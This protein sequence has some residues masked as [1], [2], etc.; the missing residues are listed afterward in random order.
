MVALV[1]HGSGERALADATRFLS[2]PRLRAFKRWR[3]ERMAETVRWT[4]GHGADVTYKVVILSGD[5]G[6]E[7]RRAPSVGPP[8]HDKKLIGQLQRQRD[9]GRPSVA[10]VCLSSGR[11]HDRSPDSHFIPKASNLDIIIPV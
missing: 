5:S 7:E 10:L 9:R 2:E 6:E 11:R 3:V 4:W 1:A 8:S